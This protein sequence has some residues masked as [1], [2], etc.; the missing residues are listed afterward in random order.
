[1]TPPQKS[2]PYSA[3]LLLL[4]D[5]IVNI[6]RS[7]MR[8]LAGCALRVLGAWMP[9]LNGGVRRIPQASVH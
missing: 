8:S 5:L 7:P 4:D 2:A 9:P 6:F 1:M 3:I